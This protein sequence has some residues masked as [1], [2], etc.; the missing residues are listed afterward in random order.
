VIL[1]AWDLLNKQS[2][3]NQWA[4]AAQLTVAGLAL[5]ASRTPEI[6]A[7]SETRQTSAAAGGTLAA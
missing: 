7:T 5:A 1:A 6:T 3:M 2:F 4:L